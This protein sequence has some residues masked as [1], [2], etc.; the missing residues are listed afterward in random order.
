MQHKQL[1]CARL[2]ALLTLALL[3][4]GP[5]LAADMAKPAKPDPLL[6]GGPTDPCAAGPVYA[7]GADVN[8]HPV[9]GADEGAMPIPVPEG[10]A[11]PLHAGQAPAPSRRGF[12]PGPPAQP[13]E[14]PY[15]MLDGRRIEPLVNPRPCR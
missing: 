10:I 11:V 8:G 6:D 5:A 9:A 1:Y 3:A 7:G 13:G 15:V 4:G 14:Q 2:G 12:R